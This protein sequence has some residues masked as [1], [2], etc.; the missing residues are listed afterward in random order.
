MLAPLKNMD[1]IQAAKAE[2]RAATKKRL[3]L[4]DPVDRLKQQALIIQQLDDWVSAIVMPASGLLWAFWPT[5]AEEPDFR[6]W[7]QMLAQKNVAFAL[8]RMDWATR[9]LRFHQVQG[10]QTDLETTRSGVIQPRN[11]C[12]PV[13]TSTVGAILVPG[14]AFD[15][16]GGRLGRGAGFYDRTLA[17]LPPEVPRWAVAFPDQIVPEIPMQAWDVRVH[18]LILPTGYEM[19]K[20]LSSK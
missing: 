5:L 10:P 20:G 3:A 12:Q 2:L 14:L 15:R 4:L 17:T 19:C 9:T 7:L 11:T 8:P 16:Q 1:A 13:A 18:G 6:A